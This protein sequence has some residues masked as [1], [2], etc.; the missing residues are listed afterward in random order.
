MLNNIRDLLEAI[1]QVKI[2]TKYTNLDLYSF[3]KSIIGNYCYTD[4]EVSLENLEITNIKIKSVNNTI[5]IK[6]PIKE[7]SFWKLLDKL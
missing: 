1:I 6:F 3:F 7:E 4:I 2:D 5:H